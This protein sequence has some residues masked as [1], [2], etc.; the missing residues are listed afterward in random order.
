MKNIVLVNNGRTD[1]RIMIP[2]AANLAEKYAAEQLQKY[3]HAVSGVSLELTTQHEGTVI[4]V[5]KTELFE[6]MNIDMNPKTFNYDG[7][8]IKSIDKNIVIQGANNRGI[9]YGV[10]EFIESILGVKFLAPNVNYIPKKDR[11]EIEEL[12]KK[13]IPEFRYRLFYDGGVFFDQVDPEYAVHRRMF[14]DFLKERPEYGYEPEWCKKLPSLHNI[15]HYISFEKYKDEHPEFFASYTDPMPLVDDVCYLNGLNDDGTVDA[16]KEISVFKIVLQ[17]LKE[18]IL[19]DSKAKF[20]C[21]CL[22]DGAKHCLCERCQKA[23][24]KYGSFS[25]IYILFMNAISREIELWQKEIGLERDIN[26]QFYIYSHTYEAPMDKDSDG[27]VFH[28]LRLRD[29]VFGMYCTFVNS[30]YGI[31]DKRQTVPSCKNLAQWSKFGKNLMVWE[32][33]ACFDS[34]LTYFPHLSFMKE[35]Y[36]YY[37]NFS[38][39]ILSQ[40]DYTMFNSWTSLVRSYVASKLFWN[41]ELDTYALAE[42]FIEYYHGEFAPYLKEFF[43]NFEH[44][45]TKLAEKENFIVGNGDPALW[46]TK[47]NFTKEFLEDNM[48][49]LKEALNCVTHSNL[50]DHDKHEHIERITQALLIPQWM[51]LQIHC[52][53]LY[54]PEY[55]EFFDE[56]FENLKLCKQDEDIKGTFMSQ[57]R[58]G[59]DAAYYIHEDRACIR[60][61]E[62]IS[63]KKQCVER[64]VV[65]KENLEHVAKLTKSNLQDLNQWVEEY[66]E[67]VLQNGVKKTSGD[68]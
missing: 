16:G 56:L 23:I 7:F 57:L 43:Y 42:E 5:G 12:D 45:Y 19:Q 13:E 67:D 54:A 25:A 37:K 8:I 58:E 1:Y 38:P 4:S 3:I 55:D 14:N 20:F 33:N 24:K 31:T 28:E 18:Y 35:N 49:L 6:S 11:I 50:G 63:Y 27:N 22:N 36:C 51:Y 52:D 30:A 53:D 68:F 66:K 44:L 2:Q 39:Y 46:C 40:S 41:L 10:N 60:F 47:E 34:Y 21:I 48:N 62:S 15:F 61:L 17:S 64:V 9:V 65:R 59:F 32:Y 29:N 26:L